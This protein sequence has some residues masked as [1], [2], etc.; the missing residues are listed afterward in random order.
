MMIEKIGAPAMCEQAAEECTELAKAFL[1][2]ARIIR[3]E[4]PTPV[5]MEEAMYIKYMERL[6]DLIGQR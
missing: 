6:S 5:T 4:N 2:L 1:K 3:N